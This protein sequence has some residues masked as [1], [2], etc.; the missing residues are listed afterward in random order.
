MT[1]SRGAK[2]GWKVELDAATVRLE[3]DVAPGPW[4]RRQ[5]PAGRHQL[6]DPADLLVGIRQAGL[7]EPVAGPDSA[8]RRGDE[9]LRS[10]ALEDEDGP[11]VRSEMRR[12]RLQR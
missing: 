6:D 9:R 2:R 3:Q 7:D 4:T 10:P 5:R 11:P 8:E 1:A 12:D